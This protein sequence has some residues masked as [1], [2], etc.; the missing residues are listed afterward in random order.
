MDDGSVLSPNA[1]KKMAANRSRR[2]SRIRVA[3]WAV[4]PEIA[5]PSMKAPTAAET[6][7]ADAA[8]A[9]S[10]AAPRTL[11]RK[12]SEFS[13][14]TALETWCPCRSATMRTMV[15]TARAMPTAVSPPRKLTPASVAVRMGR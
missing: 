9:T 7:I 1:T 13:L 4:E 8:P 10:R 15:T 2:G 3:L 5:M 6:C 14:C 12:T 11:S